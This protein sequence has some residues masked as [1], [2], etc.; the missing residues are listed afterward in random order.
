MAL[1]DVI[2]AALATI[3]WADTGHSTFKVYHGAVLGK[4][5]VT[6]FESEI[7][8]HNGLGT[9]DGYK[10][11]ALFRTLADLRGLSSSTLDSY[12]AITLQNTP[13]LGA[14]HVPDNDTYNNKSYFCTYRYGQCYMYSVAKKLGVA[15]DKWNSNLAW[16][17]IKSVL[18]I[19]GH[20]VLFLNTSDN[21]YV[22]LGN[23]LY[24]ENAQSISVMIEL[25]EADKANNAGALAYA[26]DTLWA[27]VN[28]NLWFTDHYGYNPGDSGYECEGPFFAIVAARLRAL[29][30]YTLANWD[31]VI[32]DVKSRFLNN[33]WDS[34]QWT[35]GTTR[36][37]AV[38]HH[39]TANS[40]RRLMNTIGAWTVLHAFYR[41]LDP[42]SQA[43]IQNLL[44]GPAGPAWQLL[45][46]NS[47][48]FD[49]T[50]N[51]FRWTSD[52][53][54]NDDATAAGCV[55][56]FLLGIVPQ[57]GSLLV[58]LHEFNYECRGGST[59]NRYF[60]FN[61]DARTIRIPVK[62]GT[63]Q[64]IYGTSPVSYTFPA[65]GVYEIT[66]S[67]D[68]NSITSVSKV[69]DVDPTLTYVDPVRTP[70]KLTLTVTPL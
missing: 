32:T 36:Y 35:Y 50:A 21:T 10:L 2:G 48:L 66:F 69:G 49:S 60:L 25:Y 33:G 28:N 5:D 54:T 26:R 13:F 47:G 23:R 8:Y 52:G 24:D 53:T 64:F 34:P 7:N 17:E 61:Y 43:A 44:N 1:K 39:H 68:W 4:Y 18:D 11:A 6:T 9:K 37:Y 65:N 70:T 58:P 22:D 16:Q 38:V 19:A 12:T 63:I 45:I 29:N 20:G 30:G 14:T 42:T 41:V 51:R 67:S 62:A 15:T 59:L 27:Y 3:N 46:N 55:L 57:D 40:Q 31:R 56:L